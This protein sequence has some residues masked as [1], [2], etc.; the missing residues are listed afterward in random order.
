MPQQRA[1]GNVQWNLNREDVVCSGNEKPHKCLSTLSHKT[2]YAKVLKNHEVKSHSSP[3]GHG[4]RNISAENGGVVY[5]G[6][7]TNP[8]SKRNMRSSSPMWDHSYYRVLSQQNE[9]DSRLG[10]KKQFGFLRMKASSP[11]VSENLSIEGNQ[12]TRKGFQGSLPAL[13]LRQDDQALTQIMNQAR[14][15]RLPGVVKGK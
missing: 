1:G 15:N 7:E 8:I 3:G 4:S 9:C 12:S 6:F 2:D 5:P 11:V 13:S 14:I 10:V